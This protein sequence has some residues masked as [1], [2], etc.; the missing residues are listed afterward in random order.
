MATQE[1]VV[2]ADDSLSTS[3]PAHGSISRRVV[4]AGGGAVLASLGCR[5]RLSLPDL[6][7]PLDRP[8]DD[9]QLRSAPQTPPDVLPYYDSLVLFGSAVVAP[10][11]ASAPNVSALANPHGLPMEI[12][13][14]KFRLYPQSN[15]TDSFRYVSGMSIGVK[16][17]LGA[18]AISD[19]K[20][21]IDGFGNS[22][23]DDEVL[24]SGTNVFVDPADET[25]MVNPFEYTWRL[26]YPLFVPTG[27]VLT[28]V[29]EHLG[30]N[31]FPIVVEVIY[32]A[33]SLPPDYRPPKTV[34]V[35]WVAAFNSNSYDNVATTPAG[36]EISPE[37]DIA[38]NFDVP[39]EISRLTGRCTL[40]RVGSSATSSINA[41]EEWNGEHR[42][43]AG[44]IRIRGSRGDE[45]A[46]VKTIFDG[47]WPITWRAWDIPG[48]W[49]MRPGEFYKVQLDVAAL[50]ASPQAVDIGRVQYAISA[51]GYRP[52]NTKILAEAALQA[53]S[54]GEVVP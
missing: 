18:M 47:L 22:R 49:I 31:P 16:F 30:Q 51:I 10:G 19:Q 21:P 39:L 34:M 23:D 45:L 42:F 1:E 11:G 14:I 12:R 35:P 28:P 13:E 41:S 32:L 40:V 50:L 15:Q 5:H 4:I 17:D 29:F 9:M 36:R 6:L 27:G 48:G 25:V 43:V 46:R 2:K 20:M 8:E 53:V 33:C 38:N 37:L 52:I 24:L 26:K 3:K 54:P 44:T 7:D